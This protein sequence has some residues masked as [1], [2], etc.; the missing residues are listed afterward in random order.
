MVMLVA[1]LGAFTLLQASIAMKFTSQFQTLSGQIA[2]QK[3]YTIFSASITQIQV[4][5]IFTSVLIFAGLKLLLKFTR[6]G[7]AVVA[8]SDDEEVAKIV[9]INTNQIIG[10]VFFIGSSIAGLAGIFIG[11]DTGME[12]TMG[13]V[14][15]LSAIVACI[16]GGVR[17]L[18]GA[19][20]GAFLVALAENFGIWKI[21]GEWRPAIA[22]ALLILFL[23]FR[24]QGIIK[25]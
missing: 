22:Y 9:G 23:L 20:L 6:F 11:L 8:V 4:L 12:P 17:S 19:F 16:V 21:A 13:L 24:P 25:E 5:A 1:S 3:I 10:W 7:K 15:L 18:S 2:N 14:L